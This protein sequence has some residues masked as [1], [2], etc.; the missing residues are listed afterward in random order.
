[1][2]GRGAVKHPHPRN[3]SEADDQRRLR[4][5]HQALTANAEKPVQGNKASQTGPPDSEDR[6]ETGKANGD[7][8]EK[9]RTKITKKRQYRGLVF[10]EPGKGGGKKTPSERKLKKHFLT[11]NGG[12]SIG[13]KVT[14]SE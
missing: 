8:W 13:N 6:K 9:E 2:T 4:T 10:S 14:P 3:A 7:L 1:M 12:T 11:A 5:E